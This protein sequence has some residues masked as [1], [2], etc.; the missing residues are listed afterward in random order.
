MQPKKIISNNLKMVLDCWPLI[1]QS[2]ACQWQYLPFP[3]LLPLRHRPFWLQFIEKRGGGFSLIAERIPI[4]VW[5]KVGRIKWR[6]EMVAISAHTFSLHGFIMTLCLC[7]VIYSLFSSNNP[8]FTKVAEKVAYYY[9][10]FQ[11]G[12]RRYLNSDHAHLSA[13]AKRPLYC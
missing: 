9:N 6:E 4:N 3:I 11:I 10:L 1:T 2:N 12:L 5:H 7:R 8:F 13:K